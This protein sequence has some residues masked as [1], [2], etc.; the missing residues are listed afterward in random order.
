MPGQELVDRAIR[1]LHDRGSASPAELAQHVF[2]GASF[3]P[4]LGTL[5][6]ERLAFDGL[7]WSLQQPAEEWAIL[8]VLTTGPNPARH[9]IVEVAAERQ[10]KRFQALVASGK[11]VPKLLRRLGVP[12]E[13]EEFLP[14]DEVVRELRRFLGGAT[15]AGIGYVPQF[16]DVLL[17]PCWPAIDLLRLVEEAGFRGRPDPLRL[18]RH[19]GLPPPLSRRP[20]GLLPL[21]Q[22]LFEGLRRD[23]SREDLLEMAR[24]RPFSAPSAPSLPSQP[25]VYIMAESRGEPLYVGK[26]VDLKR[27]VSSYL[28]TPIALSRNM[29][30]LMRRTERI[31]V[32]PVRSELEAL[33][34]ESQLIEAWLPP[35][36]IQRRTRERRRYLRLSVQ[37]PFPRLTLCTAPDADG[38]LYFGPLRHAAAAARL[39]H[40][41]IA[42]LRLRTCTRRLPPPRK[43]APPC[44]K[45]GSGACLAPCV[46]GPPPAP[47]SAE[48]ELARSL[49]GA[50]PDE[51]RRILRQL[52]RERPPAP[53][54]ALRMK[55]LVSR[56]KAWPQALPDTPR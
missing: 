10:G 2:G 30:D 23:H 24:P 45:A 25:G 53:A 41:L 52:L 43:P 11:P 20:A 3:A 22:S 51:F 34:L 54:H 49:L 55:R 26:S 6:D 47:Y 31:E 16:L 28:R 37:E 46:I 40:L 36:N 5:G 7:R 39:H 12:E 32:V 27:R 42:V 17:G 50:S 18:A 4:L 8:E 13:D 33:L 19:F 44:G 14:L 15:V 29:H 1:F 21:S 48:V 56:I 35:F 9:R 38:S